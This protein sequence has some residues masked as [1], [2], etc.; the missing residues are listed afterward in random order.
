MAK[1]LLAL[2]IQG[3]SHPWHFEFYGDPSHISDWRA[4]GLV[5]EEVEN[6][7]PESLPG[8]IPSRLWAFAQDIFNFRSPWSP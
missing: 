7:V 8:F 2:Q 5:V 3:Q 1:K 6:T 4:D